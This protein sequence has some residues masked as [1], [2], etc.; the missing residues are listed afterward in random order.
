MFACNHPLMPRLNIIAKGN[1]DV[2]SVLHA[3]HEDGAVRWNG[4]NAILRERRPGWTAR[5]IH[6]TMTRS[7]AVLAATA[8]VPPALAGRAL[9]L[10]PFPAGSQFHSRLFQEPAEVVVLSIQP[11][12]TN[13]LVRHRGDGHLFSPYGAGSWP[14]AD[15]R[16]L[17]DNY[18]PEPLLQAG[19]SM[20]NF[21]R[22]VARL[23]RNGDPLILIFNLSPIVP[24]ERVHCYQGV[25]ETLVQR[26]RRFNLA[27]TELS[28]DTGI[29][30]V[31][32]DAVLA[33]AGAARLKVDA[34]TLTA[35][36]CQLV[37]EEVVRVLDDLGCFAQAEAVA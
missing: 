7:D 19:Q 33:R 18:L 13:A 12:V 11:D 10:G 35:E 21:A 6:E 15:R 1:A 16:W 9:R 25:G 28:A 8:V 29:S 36:G 4:L 14:A 26:I 27:L 31:D 22:I 32:V 5:V 17:A 3:L 23:R 30:I 20:D 2:R 34:M 37:C 24:W